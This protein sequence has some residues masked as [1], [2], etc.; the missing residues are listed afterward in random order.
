MV[1]KH[2]HAGGESRADVDSSLNRVGWDSTQ[3]LQG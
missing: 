3:E 1:N 2:V